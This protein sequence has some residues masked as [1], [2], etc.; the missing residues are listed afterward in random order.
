[1][2]NNS[3]QVII[4]SEDFLI[5]DDIKEYKSEISTNERLDKGITNLLSNLGYHIYEDEKDKSLLYVSGCKG[6]DE[7]KTI[8]INNKEEFNVNILIRLLDIIDK[9]GELIYIWYRNWWLNKNE[10][11]QRLHFLLNR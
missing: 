5:S 10:E 2:I 11:V 6:K 3:F 8:F 4:K 1:M 9:R 7:I